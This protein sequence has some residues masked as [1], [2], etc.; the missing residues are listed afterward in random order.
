MNNDK[1]TQRTRMDGKTAMAFAGHAFEQQ[2][3]RNT[4]PEWLQRCTVA[5]YGKDKDGRFIV[6]LAVTLKA[7][8]NSETYFEALVDPETAETTVLTGKDPSQYLGE[9]LLGF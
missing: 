7:T 6:S 3:P 2:R 5:S 9:D 8:G 4:W 1:Q